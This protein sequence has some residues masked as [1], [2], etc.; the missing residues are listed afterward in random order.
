MLVCDARPIPHPPL[1]NSPP[2][3]YGIRRLVSLQGLGTTAAKRDR[4]PRHRQNTER[5]VGRGEEDLHDELLERVARLYFIEVMSQ[6]EIASVEHLS[7]PS[8]SRLLAEA[9]T[10][11]VVQF[12]V[13]PPVDRVPELETELLRRT[14]LRRCVVAMSRPRALY[15]NS[16]RLGYVAARHLET[17]LG[18]AGLLGIASS[19]SLSSVVDF[20]HPTHSYPG[21]TVVDLLGCLPAGS[22]AGRGHGGSGPHTA[23]F[24]ADRLG[25]AFHPLPAPFVYRSGEARDAA[26]GSEQ[27]R[28]TLQMGQNCDV[29][30][31]GIGSMQ[32]FDGTG[33]YS[34][35][36]RRE[37]DSLAALGAVG[38]VCGHFLREDGSL[39]A[40]AG[41]PFLLGI[42]VHQLRALP[43]RIAVAASP[44]KV[45]PLAAVIRAG[46]ITELV[47]DSAT[48]ASLTLE[49]QG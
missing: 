6:T 29:A 2:P 45:P 25:A 40:E 21:L 12:R 3:P 31:V 15:G 5:L 1:S 36:P 34:P 26:L 49:F 32:R 41:P 20:L 11:G 38:H 22:G 48:A 13:G 7:R 8:V 39:V 23:Q 18:A 14:G 37:L 30:M 19:R 9:K 27:I 28:R 10:R 47:T 46:L 44:H 33:G 17:Q 42:G 43:Q 16:S 24:V 4:F 35:I